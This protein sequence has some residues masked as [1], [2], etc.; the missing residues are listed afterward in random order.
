MEVPA[1]SSTG[2]NYAPSLT[3]TG[4]A[5]QASSVATIDM[6]TGQAGA[7]SVTVASQVNMVFAQMTQGSGIDA[8]TLKALIMLLLIQLLMNDGRTDQTQQTLDSLAQAFNAAGNSEMT[9]VAMQASSMIQIQFGGADDASAVA[10]EAGA[11]A[12]LDVQ[13]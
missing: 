2:G 6:Q 13:A 7:M 3:Y 8:K 12:S 4:A 5:L 10:I 11:G 1:I 9:M